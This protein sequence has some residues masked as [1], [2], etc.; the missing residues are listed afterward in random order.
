[1]SEFTPH[2]SSTEII[3]GHKLVQSV[4]F[5]RV[6]SDINYAIEVYPEDEREQQLED[7]YENIFENDTFPSD[8]H[9]LQASFTGYA[10]YPASPNK[11]ALVSFKDAWFE[12]LDIQKNP[13]D[14]D[15]LVMQFIVDRGDD[16]SMF[17]IDPTPENV[18][19]L[20]FYDDD[21]ESVA[22]LIKRIERL[23]DAAQKLVQGDKFLSLKPLDQV[24]ALGDIAEGLYSEFVAMD[25]VYDSTTL[26][27]ECDS[28]YRIPR[29]SIGTLQKWHDYRIDVADGQTDHNPPTG[30]LDHISVP[31]IPEYVYEDEMPLT[32]MRELA[33][34]DGLPFITLKDPSKNYYDYIPVNAIT[35][36]SWK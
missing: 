24:H 13:N 27:I 7:A 4:D 5:Q 20:D 35:N 15:R 36:I 34:S 9:Q 2:T 6:L 19:Q 12:G 17:A 31:D 32:D 25:I 29:H 16:S 28:Y 18:L 1:M 3:Q 33:I 23:G 30:R 10:R 26:T 21:T 8:V 22:E 11:P 14:K